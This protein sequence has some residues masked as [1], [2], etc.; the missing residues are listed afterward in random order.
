MKLLARQWMLGH[1]CHAGVEGCRCRR[2]RASVPLGAVG[3]CGVLSRLQA[4]SGCHWSRM[5]WQRAPCA[6]VRSNCRWGAAK[7]ARAKAGVAWRY[8]CWGEARPSPELGPSVRP[9]TAM[10]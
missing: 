1:V 9:R 2:L 8:C 10:G 3:I 7:W 5:R 4:L 6:P